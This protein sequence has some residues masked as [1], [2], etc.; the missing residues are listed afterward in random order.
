VADG[1]RADSLITGDRRVANKQGPLARGRVVAR[2]REQARL[3][4]GVGSSARGGEWRGRVR[5]V[6][7]VGRARCAGER[8]GT[9]AGIGPAGGREIPFS[10]L[11][12][13]PN[14]FYFLLFY[15]L[16]F[17]LNNYL[18][19]F[20]GCQ[21]ILREVLLTTIVYAYDE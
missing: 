4:G 9:W 11:F 5:G 1:D 6:G 8:G 21:N 14:L 17:P 10:F 13:F 12:L 18:S 20:V 2:E 3:M 16:L 7:R 19:I 15:N